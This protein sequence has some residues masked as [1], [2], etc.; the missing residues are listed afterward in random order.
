[1]IEH[2]YYRL[3][4]ERCVHIYQHKKEQGSPQCARDLRRNHRYDR[5]GAPPVTEGTRRA[6]RIFDAVRKVHSEADGCDGGCDADEPKASEYKS[7]VKP[8]GARGCGDYAVLAALM[9]AFAI[10]AWPRRIS[11]SP[12]A[13][14]FEALSDV[15][16]KYGSTVSMPRA[17]PGNRIKRAD[18]RPRSSR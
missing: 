10:C 17:A 16:N 1:M 9:R 11:P 18:R 8:S 15:L 3:L 12:P 7:D 2:R 6:S 13:S 4:D 5:S 14:L